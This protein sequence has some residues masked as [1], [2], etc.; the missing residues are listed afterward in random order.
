MSK[1]K[2]QYVG[3]IGYCDNATLGIKDKYGNPVKGGHYVY[4]GDVEKAK[5]YAKAA[6]AQTQALVAAAEGNYAPAAQKLSGYNAAIAQYMNGDLAAAKKSIAND[7]SAKADYLRAV[8]AAKEGNINNAKAQLNSAV[9]KDPSL[10]AKAEKDV[11][12]EALYK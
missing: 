2:K 10:A 12:L 4:N 1:Q 7:N 6:D 9:A 11:N 3:K 8:I 5:V